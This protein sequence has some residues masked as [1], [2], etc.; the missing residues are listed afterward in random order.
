MIPFTTYDEEDP[1]FNASPVA[2]LNLVDV[3]N[4]KMLKKTLAEIEKQEGKAGKNGKDGKDGY[5]PKRGE[6][7]FTKEEIVTFLKAVTPQKGIHYRDGERGK[8]GEK[9]KVSNYVPVVKSR[10]EPARNVGA[11]WLKGDFD[12]HNGHVSI[13]MNEAHR[14]LVGDILIR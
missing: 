8:D 13:S 3:Q 1:T 14:P 10:E 4:I 12:T 9:P 2:R 7:Y 11:I 5:T 6:D